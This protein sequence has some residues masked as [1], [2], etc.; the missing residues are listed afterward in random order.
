[1]GFAIS[2]IFPVFIHEGL[3][4]EWVLEINF[5]EI[6]KNIKTEKKGE[7]DMT[8]KRKTSSISIGEPKRRFL[9]TALVIAVGAVIA[10][11]TPV[12]AQ[13]PP[14]AV[15]VWPTDA[16]A[17]IQAAVDGGGVV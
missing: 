6:L 5:S 7:R 16:L 11:S 15:E 13:V 9:K 4:Q 1:M 3:G 12:R 2:G 14:G 10:V 8:K 17:T